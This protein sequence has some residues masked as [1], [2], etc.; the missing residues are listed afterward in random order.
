[1]LFWGGD[2]ESKKNFNY[3][4]ESSMINQQCTKKYFLQ[5][6]VSDVKYTP[7][8]MYVHNGDGILHKNEHKQVRLELWHNHSTCHPQSQSCRTDIKK[9]V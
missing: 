2:G 4:K 3:T 7:I 9:K 1:M 8:A 5:G 6:I